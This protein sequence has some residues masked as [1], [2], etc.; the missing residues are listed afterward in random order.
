MEMLRNLYHG[1][2]EKGIGGK[3]EKESIIRK[4]TEPRIFPVSTTDGKDSGG[5]G[6]GDLGKRELGGK[7][8]ASY[9][10]LPSVNMS[11]FE[12]IK[13]AE[14]K[15]VAKEVCYAAL[16]A[17]SRTGT[18]SRVSVY[19]SEFEYRLVMVLSGTPVLGT[20]QIDSIR[21][22]AVGRIRTILYSVHVPGYRDMQARFQRLRSTDSWLYQNLDEQPATLGVET[23]VSIYLIRT[24]LATSDRNKI[25]GE[26]VSS[27]ARSRSKKRRRG[28]SV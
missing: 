21:A 10:S 1:L 16:R 20:D 2:G 28:K 25:E 7:G 19:E 8:T 22:S 9:R 24:D 27:E 12:V 11:S 3:G 13:H 6:K 14:D 23:S 15:A 4:D 18:V 5:L 26:L 17:L